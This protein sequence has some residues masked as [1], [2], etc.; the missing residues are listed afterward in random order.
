MSLIEVSDL[1]FSYEGSP[2]P[3]FEGL[4]LQLD[5]DW[6]L[7]FTGRNGRGK[8]TLLRLLSGAYPYGGTITASVEPVYFPYPVAQPEDT[9]QAVA[10][11]AAPE[12][13]DWQ[14]QR[15][16]GLLDLPLELLDRPFS[17]LSPGE[18]TRVLLAALFLRRDAYPLIDEP[19]NHLDLEGRRKLAAYLTRKRGFL[20]VSHDRDFLDRCTD[21]TL[22]LTPTG[23]QVR[24]GS[25]SVWWENH[26]QQMAFEQARQEKLQ[27]DI[28]RL[29]EAARRASAWSDR[30]E[31]GK[32]GVDKTGAKAADRG[33][34]GHQAAKMM[35]RSKAIQRRREEAAEEKAGLLRD[36]EKQE[37]LL[38]RP[39]SS[40][41]GRRLIELREVSIAYDNRTVCAGVTFAVCSGERIALRGPNG[42]GKTSL[43]RLVLGELEPAAGQVE[44]RSGLV[45]SQ[46]RQNA[47]HLEGSL[48][49]FIRA[50]RLDPTRF[51]TV[52]RKLDFPRSQFEKDL[53]AYSAGQKKKVLLAASLCEEA[54]LYIWDEPLNYVDVLSRIQ[55]EELILACRP[56][57][58]LVEHDG[59]F[60]DTVATRTVEL[61]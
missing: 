13:E 12:A 9:V 23:A 8:T 16:L 46:V 1:T 51:H 29:N 14:L 19:T 27:K 31:Q 6:K 5:T 3:V 22:A 32:F 36:A 57:L 7:G 20:L 60:C 54:D 41:P 42:C 61:G 39:R 11:A 10:A 38:L 55:L 43:L 24:R 45:I 50:R 44:R 59:R 21:H 28:R 49:D 34:V 26:Q 15:E 37:T 4:T 53:C 2:Q 56:T 47:D 25:F 30:T 35:K 33:Y 40:P 52:L 58:L 48:S 17:T 18:R